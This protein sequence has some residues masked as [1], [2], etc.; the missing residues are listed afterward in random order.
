MEK[1]AKGFAN[2]KKKGQENEDS[3]FEVFSVASEY[4]QYFFHFKVLRTLANG[5]V[6]GRRDFYDE[7]YYPFLKYHDNVLSMRDKKELLRFADE[8]CLYELKEQ[9]I[10][11]LTNIV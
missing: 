6:E 11:K 9:L 5:I 8:F 10:T 1:D 3:P 4:N 2:I 7:I